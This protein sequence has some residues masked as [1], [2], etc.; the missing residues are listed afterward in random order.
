MRIIA[1]KYRGRALLAPKG[2][3]TRPTTDR[4]RESL[5]STLYSLRGGFQGARVLDAFAGT[6][7]LGLEA[8]SRGAEHALFCEMN[9]AALKVVERNIAACKLDRGSYDVRKGDVLAAPPHLRL[10]FDMVLLDPPYAL[11]A[12]SVFAFLDHMAQAG[13]LAPDC[14]VC[15]EHAASVQVGD[16]AG[17]AGE[18]WALEVERK[19]GKIAVDIYRRG[20]S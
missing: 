4:V 7:A 11:P 15:Y 2:D 20:L 3:D 9:P 18:P 13:A 19:Y 1:G 8:L 6:G 12:A 16:A 10:P 17:A 5:F 14:I